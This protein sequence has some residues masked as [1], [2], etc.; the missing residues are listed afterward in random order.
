[1]PE[2]NNFPFLQNFNLMSSLV[3]LRTR[4][5][6]DRI[7]EMARRISLSFLSIFMFND[8][9][10]KITKEFQLALMKAL[11]FLLSL[12]NF[13]QYFYSFSNFHVSL[14]GIFS[15]ICVGYLVLVRT[16]RFLVY[17]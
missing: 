9:R 10:T 12:G 7:L 6:Y 3:K 17:R 14:K 1:M 2:K 8:F 15:F 13:Y 16:G 11:G 4:F 5:D